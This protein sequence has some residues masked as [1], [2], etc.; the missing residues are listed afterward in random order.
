MPLAFCYNFD[1][2]I[3]IVVCVCVR[4]VFVQGPI[5][6]DFSQVFDVVCSLFQIAF[7]YQLSVSVDF[8]TTCPN[9]NNHVS[10]TFATL[11]ILMEGTL[12]SRG[13]AVAAVAGAEGGAGAYVE[14]IILE[15]FHRMFFG[16]WRRHFVND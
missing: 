16:S 11:L 14:A 6:C 15:I 4:A 9:I 12:G 13:A 2:N 8:E 1:G 5:R 10:Q 3:V 7:C